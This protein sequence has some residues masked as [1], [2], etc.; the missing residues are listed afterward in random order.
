MTLPNHYS[1][2]KEHP[3]SFEIHDGRDNSRFHIAK[4]DIHPATQIKLMKMQKFDEGG[5]VEDESTSEAPAPQEEAPEEAAPQAPNVT[6]QFVPPEA[7]MPVNPQAPVVQ[8]GNV[9]YGAPEVQPP[10]AQAQVDPYANVPGYAENLKGIQAQAGVKNEYGQ[11]IQSALNS[12]TA[13]M[14][15]QQWKYEG[16]RK[17][18]DDEQS[19]LQKK[20]QNGEVDPRRY[21]KNMNT[22][23]R[24]ASAIGLILGGI[25]S[26]LG[27]TPNMAAEMMNKAVDNDIEAQKMDLGKTNSLL[28]LNLQKYH[29]LNTAEAATRL[30]YNTV[31]QTQ[32]QAAQN[33]ATTNLAQAGLQMQLGQLKMQAEQYKQQ[34]ALKGVEAQGLGYASGEGGLPEGREPGA[35]LLDPKYREKRVVVNGKAYQAS[36]KEGAAKVR[37]V[38][39]LARPVVEGVKRLQELG[40]DPLTMVAGTQQNHEAHGLIGDLAVKLPLLS[41]AQIGAKRI[42]SEEIAHQL[43]RIKDPT[44]MDNTMA[45]IKND[46]FFKSLEGELESMRSNHLVGYKGSA[47]VPSFQPSTGKLPLN[48]KR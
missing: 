13:H 36:D 38:E 8:P 3:D 5:D 48:G 45:G 10:Q 46:Q 7:Q 20:L 41:G 23:Q 2:A 29:N 16:E 28:N 24:I 15:E 47:A 34:M 4:K 35:L 33:K 19:V 12:H 22:G 25:G 43:A 31:L 42:N 37:D 32:L 14:A 21:F 40:S 26:G 6:P 30:Q 11:E 17:R 44:R 9:N 39:T 18:I 27:H 1:L